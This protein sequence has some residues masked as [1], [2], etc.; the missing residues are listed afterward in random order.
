MQGLSKVWLA[1]SLLRWLVCH[2]F[3]ERVDPSRDPSVAAFLE[4]YAY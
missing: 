4:L 2:E 3:G 1:A